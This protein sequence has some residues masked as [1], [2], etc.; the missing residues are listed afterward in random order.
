[1]VSRIRGTQKILDF[2]FYFLLRTMHTKKKL[3]NGLTLITAPLKETKAVTVLVLLPV[4]S[5]H[6]T[7]STNGV[8]HFIEHLLFKGTKKRPTSLDVTKELDAVGAEYNAFTSKDH[9]G[10][11]VKLAADKIELAFDI[12]SDML[13]HAAF[14]AAEVEK[15]RGVIIEEINMYEDNPLIHV[16]T[17]FEQSVFSSHPL[18]WPISGPR[19]V[20]RNVSRAQLLAHKNRFYSPSAMVLTVAGSFDRA[21]VAKLAERYF[22]RV[23]ASQSR[24]AIHRVTI[25]Q[26]KPRAVTMYK[27]TQ[28]IQLCLGFS[29]YGLSSPNIF[30]LAL[31]S[32]ILGGNMSSRLFM[33]IREQHSLAYN[34]RA[35]AHSYQDAGTFMVQAGVDRQRL[36]QAITLILRELRRVKDEPVSAKELKDAKAFLRGK[37]ILDLEDSESV[38]DWFGKQELMLGKLYTP[39]ERLKKIFAVTPAQIQRVAREVIRTQRLNLALIGPYRDGTSFIKLLKV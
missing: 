24:G 15:E 9:T 25:G 16:E 31:L 13:L 11:Y 35:G 3:T 38:A 28:Q 20:I 33:V 39:Q 22:G 10:Y 14:P 8:S 27:K 23:S 2:K 26:T 30:P 18:G 34:I 29:S 19:S 17:L 32:I 36:T 21:R 1:M 12:L 5:R 37:L 7:K 6:E 4:G